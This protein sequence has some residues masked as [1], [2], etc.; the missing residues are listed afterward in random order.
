MPIDAALR[1]FQRLGVRARLLLALSFL[2]LFGVGVATTFHLSALADF[3]VGSMVQDARQITQQATTI[4]DKSLA[5]RARPED[6]IRMDTYTHT[7]AEYN[8][9]GFVWDIP[10]LLK[11]P[12]VSHPSDPWN[13]REGSE[14][15][16]HAHKEAH[17]RIGEGL[18]QLKTPLEGGHH[19]KHLV[20]TD[21]PVPVVKF[22]K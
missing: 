21:Q 14:A 6:A 5:G 1:P 17:T 16:D 2:A 12:A 19:P 18:V 13:K 4:L 3:T 22:F 9:Q 8:R 11:G 20:S 15:P 10:K 7:P